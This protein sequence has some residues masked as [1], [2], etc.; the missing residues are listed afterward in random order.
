[1]HEHRAEQ[2]KERQEAGQLWQEGNWVFATPTGRPLSPRYDYDQWKRLLTAAGLRDGRLHDARHTA[3]TVLL[4]IETQQRAVM[5]VMGWS[6][7]DM[8]TR[9]QHVTDQIRQDIA[10][11]VDGAIWQ[12][13]KVKKKPKKIKKKRKKG[14]GDDGSSGFL[15][16]V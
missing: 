8:V 4:I 16:A 11:R 3:A 6:S 14:D 5:G 2:D 1:L 10:K 15:V 13:D 9:Y 7:A 12:A